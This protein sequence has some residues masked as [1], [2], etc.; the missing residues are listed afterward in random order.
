MNTH[1]PAIDQQNPEIP[2]IP[3]LQYIYDE[4]NSEYWEN[5]GDITEDDECWIN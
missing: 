5:N 1:F 3:E 2:L 4:I